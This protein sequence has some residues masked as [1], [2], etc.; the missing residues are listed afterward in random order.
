MQLIFNYDNTANTDDGS[1]IE[2]VEGCTDVTSLI[3]IRLP[4]LDDGSCIEVVEGCTD[5]YYFQL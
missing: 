4:M 3:I 5:A 2:V 1:C